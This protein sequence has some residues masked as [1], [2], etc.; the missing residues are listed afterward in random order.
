M[1]QP[2]HIKWV[3]KREYEGITG[4]THMKMYL[5]YILLGVV[6]GLLIPGLI[7]L[8]GCDTES[9][10]RDNIQDARIDGNYRAFLKW[11]SDVDEEIRSLQEN[12]HKLIDSETMNVKAMKLMSAFNDNLAARLDNLESEPN[13]PPDAYLDD[14]DPNAPINTHLLKVSESWAKEYGTSQ[15]SVLKYNVVAAWAFAQKA[16]EQIVELEKRVAALD[17]VDPKGVK[18]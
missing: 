13:E 15:E 18:E 7:S 12:L 5:K 9:Q 8:A 17:P 1:M 11:L 14:I 10:S 2:G 4:K 6:I 3:S 16:L